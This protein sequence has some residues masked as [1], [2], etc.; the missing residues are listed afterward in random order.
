MRSTVVAAGFLLFAT[1]TA[2]PFAHLWDIQE[3]YSNAS[4]SVQFIEFFTTG[5]DE[6]FLSGVQ[7]Q[8]ELSGVPV[9]TFTFPNG[10]TGPT[11]A[12]RTF[13]VATANFAT[14]YGIT[15]DYVIPENFL[16]GG[17]DHTL[18]YGGFDQVS[19]AALPTDGVMSLNGVPNNDLP[20]ATTVNAQ[21]T[22]RNFAGQQVT[23]PE[24]T[25]ALL[26]ALGALTSLVVPRRSHRA[27][28]K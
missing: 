12:N 6:F 25:T 15:P 27:C 26:V 9:S 3:V 18:N 13:L 28:T 20:G 23:I 1:P 8:L 22:P 4:G 24:P 10:L 17:A 19:L 11:T 16:S 5:T 2:F 21:A 14:I 7:L